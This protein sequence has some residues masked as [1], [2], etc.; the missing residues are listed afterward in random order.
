MNTR[1]GT[2]R[3]A[4][5]FVDDS[6]EMIGETNPYVVSHRE[7]GPE[8]IAADQAQAQKGDW[9]GLFGRD[10]PLEL[11]LGAGNGQYIARMARL[12][13]ERDWLGLE[14]RFKRVEVAA[15]KVRAAGV[16]NAKIV[17]YNWFF[18]HEIFRDATVAG[19]HIHHPDP[20]SHHSQ[21]H[22]RI[23]DADFVALAE[24]LVVPGGTWRTKTDFAPHVDRLL[25][26]AGPSAF[27]VLDVRRD[28]VTD[29][30]PWPDE[31]ETNYQRKCRE[32]GR[33]VLAIWLRRR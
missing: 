11:E 18:L 14:L 19:L 30:A 33:P 8:L 25:D 20:W 1:P 32:Q 9:T 21:A 24:R 17:R 3:L 26:L 29:G 28:I 4:A 13:P 22:H 5:G 6:H 31:V 15:R 7:F 23:I 12:H 10:A 16:R 27:E 2:H